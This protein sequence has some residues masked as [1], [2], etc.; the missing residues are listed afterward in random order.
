M[1]ACKCSYNIMIEKYSSIPTD[2][3]VLWKLYLDTEDLQW[4]NIYKNCFKTFEEVKLRQFQYFFTQRITALNPYL[5]KCHL[6]DTELCTFCNSERESIEHFFWTCPISNFIWSSIDKWLS[7][8]GFYFPLSQINAFFGI[9]NPVFDH[10]KFQR[11]I[12][13]SCY[14]SAICT[15]V[16]I[17]TKSPVLLESNTI[18]DIIILKKI[19]FNSVTYFTTSTQFGEIWEIYQIIQMPK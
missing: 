10:T 6:S 9:S 11:I 5:F 8:N 12:C 7:E 3:Q 15:P 19:L 18:S 1:K 17:V 13:Y 14:V 2:K 4:N 16:N